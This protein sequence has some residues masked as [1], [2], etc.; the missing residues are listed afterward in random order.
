MFAD[1]VASLRFTFPMGQSEGTWF[2]A[3]EKGRCLVLVLH[4]LM[5]SLEPVALTSGAEPRLLIY[6]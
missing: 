5:A 1:I 2:K 3:P 6:A 4:E